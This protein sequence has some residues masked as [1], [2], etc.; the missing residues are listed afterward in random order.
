VTKIQTTACFWQIRRSLADTYNDTSLN[1]QIFGVF[2]GTTSETANFYTSESYDPSARASKGYKLF[3]PYLLPGFEDV[4]YDSDATQDWLRDCSVVDLGRPLWRAK[5]RS[6]NYHTLQDFVQFKLLE[7]LEPD[8][9]NNS[10]VSY[11]QDLAVVFCRLGLSL[12][13]VAPI[14]S[15][16]G[17]HHMATMYVRD[18]ARES[19]LVS[20]FS[21]PMKQWNERVFVL[22]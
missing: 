3:D 17:A 2:M 9:G 11:P 14:N 18:K 22:Y 5:L 21:E 20:Y 10:Q 16:L 4:R 12:S 8:V 13:P 7:T 6:C 15:S 1:V 19:M